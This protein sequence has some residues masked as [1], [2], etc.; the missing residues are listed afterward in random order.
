VVPPAHG[1]DSSL[2]RL[3]NRAR[4]AAQLSP[5]EKLL[6]QWVSSQA[7]KAPSMNTP[8]STPDEPPEEFVA[9]LRKPSGQQHRLAV[10]IDGQ[11][12]LLVLNSR[13]ETNAERESFLWR[14]LLHR[15]RQE[16]AL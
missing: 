6:H 11:E 12:I 1:K 4:N 2:Q 14:W 10:T 7:G 16:S 3:I 5:R 9:V 15:V 13:G 8:S